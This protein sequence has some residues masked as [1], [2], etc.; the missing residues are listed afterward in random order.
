M[1]CLLSASICFS[2]FLSSQC[3][4]SLV[5]FSFLLLCEQQ[6]EPFSCMCAAV[7]A[8]WQWMARAGHGTFAR[9]CLTRCCVTNSG[10]HVNCT[11]VP[12][13]GGNCTNYRSSSA[14]RARGTQSNISGQLSS[15]L[16]QTEAA[17]AAAA[18]AVACAAV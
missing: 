9:S 12:F 13:S 18:A 2:L 15:T 4:L 1:L 7:A 16:R 17:A 5:S 10:K 6:W 3:C 11:T 14:I 8:V